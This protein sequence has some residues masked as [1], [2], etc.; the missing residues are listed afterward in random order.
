MPCCRWVAESTLQ[1]SCPC[2]T[3]LTRLDKLIFGGRPVARACRSLHARP[4]C[5]KHESSV[6]GTDRNLEV[7]MFAFTTSLRHPDN[8]EDYGRIEDLLKETLVSVLPQSVS[9][10][11]TIIV[12]NRRPS[13][14][15]PPHAHYLNVDFPPHPRINGPH[16]DRNG[17]VLDKG[18]KIGVGLLAAREFDPQM[19]MIFDADDFVS[20][21]IVSYVRESP[22]SDGWYVSGGWM[23]SRVRNG[24]RKQDDFHRTCGTSRIVPHDVYRVP[25]DLDAS[26]T[27]DQVVDAYGDVLTNFMGAHRKAVQWHLKHGRRLRPLPF[28]AAVN[29]VDKGE[30][31]SRKALPG[32]IR[33][34]SRRCQRRYAILSRSSVL[35]T[36]WKCW[37]PLAVSETTRIAVRRMTKCTKSS[38]RG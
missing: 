22:R 28:R 33:P 23:C 7:L 4:D 38:R 36:I 18:S 31:H 19:V 29:R 5:Y 30:N 14:P 16:A 35:L 1:R 2:R 13:F 26:A 34:W 3:R 20:R 24:H 37:T 21:D 6:C 27:Q 32:V 11:V 10:H 25:F 15:L 8:A 9:D 12:G 17:F